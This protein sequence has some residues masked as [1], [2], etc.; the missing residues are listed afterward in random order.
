MSDD[1][2]LPG[3]PARVTSVLMTE[4]SIYGLLLV[5]G[6]IVVSHNLVGTSLNALLTVVVTV[7]V[8]FLAHV[9]AGTLARLAATEGLAGLRG[10]IGGAVHHSRGML[11]VS[12]VPLAILLLGVTRVFDDE[13]AIWTALLVDV[14]ILGVL[15]WL[16]VARWSPSVWLRVASSL[17]TAGFGVIVTLLKVLIHH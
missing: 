9:F 14:V 1:P 3:I 16:A 5:S 12:V 8:F 17:I 4:E 15:G 7:I 2:A 6:M 13:A 11:L 10:A